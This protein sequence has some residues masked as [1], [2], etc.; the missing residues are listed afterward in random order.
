MGSFKQDINEIKNEETFIYVRF[1]KYRQKVFGV[2]FLDTSRIIK[3]EKL[4]IK[5]NTIIH[6]CATQSID[7]PYSD[8]FTVDDNWEYHRYIENGKEKT[9]KT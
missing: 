2:P 6:C 9:K 3:C 8:Y 5:K 1:F 7:T 4:T